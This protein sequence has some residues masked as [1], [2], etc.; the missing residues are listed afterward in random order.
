MYKSDQARYAIK[1]IDPS[2]NTDWLEMLTVDT[3]RVELTKDDNA[4]MTKSFIR[5]LMAAK[6]VGIELLD[7]LNL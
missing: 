1:D 4:Q 6:A 2:I 3:D 7:D 5:G